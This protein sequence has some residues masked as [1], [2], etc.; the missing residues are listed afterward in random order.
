MNE[1]RYGSNLSPAERF[2]PRLQERPQGAEHR[3][4]TPVT[5]P[6]M[7]RRPPVPKVTP[8]MLVYVRSH[9]PALIVQHDGGR[10]FVLPKPDKG[11]GEDPSLTLLLDHLAVASYFEEAQDAKDVAETVNLYFEALYERG[12]L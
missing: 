4:M 5:R 7:P 2:R 11:D 10:V 1:R 3:R 9:K 6:T 12:L 8:G